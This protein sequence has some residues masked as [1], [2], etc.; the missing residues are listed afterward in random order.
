[1]REEGRKNER[2]GKKGITLCLIV[3]LI[4]RL[5]PES[6]IACYIF[7]CCLED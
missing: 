3:P 1:M 6:V 5:L 4:A 7:C 2:Q